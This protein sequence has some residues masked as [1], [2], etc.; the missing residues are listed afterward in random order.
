M[1]GFTIKF[2]ELDRVLLRN[3]WPICSRICTKRGIQAARILLKADKI[4]KTENTFLTA[5]QMSDNALW[6][7]NLNITHYVILL[8]VI[9]VNYIDCW[10]MKKF[11][12]AKAN[13]ALDVTSVPAVRPLPSHLAPSLADPSRTT[14]LFAARTHL[15]L[16]A[17]R[18]A[19][20]WQG[21]ISRIWT[22]H[23]WE[24]VVSH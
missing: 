22:F 18:C 1:W 16:Y 13:I 11:I 10:K 2:T 3:L 21:E 24:S 20:S 8:E 14:S 9:R 23:P 7:D 15:I 19:S 6:R 4:L 12:G 5:L 17:E